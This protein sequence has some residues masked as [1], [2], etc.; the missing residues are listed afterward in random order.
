LGDGVSGG[1]GGEKFAADRNRRVFGMS[2]VGK[3][4]WGF[5]TKICQA[6]SFGRTVNKIVSDKPLRADTTLKNHDFF[7]SFH[8][9]IVGTYTNFSRIYGWLIT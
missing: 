2:V 4:I 6:F 9:D 7:Y 1:G 5:I 8:H 3:G